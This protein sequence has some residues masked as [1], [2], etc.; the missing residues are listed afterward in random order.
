MSVCVL[1]PFMPGEIK[2]E[3]G[4]ATR[5]EMER[6]GVSSPI[7]LYTHRERAMGQPKRSCMASLERR[8]SGSPDGHWMRH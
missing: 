5:Q 7:L 2:R 4:P 3:A 1:G 6:R 8:V